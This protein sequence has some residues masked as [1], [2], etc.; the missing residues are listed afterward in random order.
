MTARNN[1]V[2]CATF[3]GGSIIFLVYAND[4]NYNVAL[5]KQAQDL[6]RKK[7]TFTERQ[8][9]GKSPLD[10]K[11]G[12]MVSTNDTSKPLSKLKASETLYVI[13]HEDRDAPELSGL[14]PKEL[15]YLLQS[16]GLNPC[17]K[18]LKIKLVCCHSGHAPRTMEPS[19]AQQFYFELSKGTH[20]TDRH[21][22]GKEGSLFTVKAPKHVIGYSHI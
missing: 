20:E 22:M 14:N 11:R 18:R 13:G 17:T 8:L 1:Q 9:Y 3:N 21:S 7:Y 4:P 5:A 10:N 16:Y 6:T 19:F 2:Q 15:A 12:K